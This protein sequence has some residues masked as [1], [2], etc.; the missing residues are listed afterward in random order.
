MYDLDAFIIVDRMPYLDGKV[1]PPDDFTV[2]FN[3]AEEFFDK[4]PEFDF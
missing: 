3:H 4:E 1:L 2:E